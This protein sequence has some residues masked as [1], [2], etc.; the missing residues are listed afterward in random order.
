[1]I[2][3]FS[4]SGPRASVA[5]VSSDGELLYAGDEPAQ[6]RAGE[7]CLRLLSEG[8]TSLGTGLRDV[9]LFAADLGPGSFTGVRVGIVLAKTFAWEAEKPCAGADAFD[10]VDP[11]TAVALPSRRG[12]WFVRTPGE[13]VERTHEEPPTVGV[14]LAS[15][16]AVLVARG[17]LNPVSAY[18]LTPA[19]LL[20]PSISKPKRD[21]G[22]PA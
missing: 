17:L 7:A 16:F 13:P 8:F 21:Y 5:L 18:E 20:E 9:K 22:R 1:V 15:G 4:T 6:G 3:A 19:Y 12:E 11:L 14:P 2:A 10:L